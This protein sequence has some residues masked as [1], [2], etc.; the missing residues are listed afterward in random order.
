MSCSFAKSTLLYSVAERGKCSFDE[1]SRPLAE[2]RAFTTW[3]NAIKHYRHNYAISSRVW[4][5]VRARLGNFPLRE[6]DTQAW[7]W[8][9][10]RRVGQVA[11]V[12]Y[13]AKVLLDWLYFR[14]I[15]RSAKKKKK[16]KRTTSWWAQHHPLLVSA[17]PKHWPAHRP[18]CKCP[19][20]MTA[21]MYL[22]YLSYTS[23]HPVET[24]ALMPS[25][26]LRVLGPGLYK[27]S[28]INGRSRKS[29][30]MNHSHI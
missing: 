27:I 26:L 2:L 25:V 21:W 16:K 19:H 18:S 11:D 22:A 14:L 10:P 5:F 23:T 3:R 17:I 15:S 6:P 29:E 12:S 13:H 8:A 20:K 30:N 28:G 24:K 1:S 4:Q 7:S 9:E